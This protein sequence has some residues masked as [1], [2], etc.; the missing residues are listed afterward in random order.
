MVMH[1]G[2]LCGRLERRQRGGLLT[3]SETHDGD[4]RMAMLLERQARLG[5]ASLLINDGLE[6]D[7]VLQRVLDS[8]RSLTGAQYG[9][10]T[11]LDGSGRME[12]FL[13]SG[14]TPADAQRLWEMPGGPEIFEYVNSIPGPWRVSDFAGHARD[15]GLPEFRPPAPM[16]SFLTVPILHRGDRVGNIHMAKRQPGQEFSQEDE[17]TLVMFAAQAAMVIANARRYRDEQRARTALE[18]LVE[19]S[20]V[21][22]AV[23][24]A[25]TGAPVSFNREVAR[26]MDGL[27]EADQSPEQFLETLTVRRADGREVSLR[28]WPLA[29]ALSAGETVRAEEITLSVPDGRSVTVLLNATPIRDAGGQ[30]ESFVV[31]L[32]DLAPLEEQERLRAE[33]LGMVSHELRAPLASI[34]G[35]ATTVLDASAELDPAELRQFL[36]IIVDQADNMRDLIGDLLDVARIETGALPVDPEPA[37]PST[38]V[39]RARNTFLS[40]EGRHSIDINLPPN[41]PLVMADRRRIVQVLGNLLSNAARNSPGVPVVRVR[42]EQEGGDVAFSVVDSGRGIPSEQLPHL[43]RKFSRTEVGD[44]GLG[45]AVCKGIVEAHGGRIWAESAG[46]GLGARFTF[47]LRAVAEA[48]A[49]RPSPQ[50]EEQEETG[51]EPIL[52]VDDDPQTLR[53]VRNALSNAGY[54]PMVTADP[55]EALRLMAENRPRLVLLD[56][57]LPGFDGIELMRDMSGIADAPVVFLSAYSGDRMIAQ[58]LEAGAADYIVKPFSPTELVARVGAAL[59]RREWPHRTEPAEPYVRDGLAI[60]YARRLVSLAGQPVE[61]TAKE[62]DLLRVLSINAGRM[63]THEQ[64]LRQVWGPDKGDLRVLRSLLLRLRRKLGEDGGNPTWIHSVPRVGYR[65][66]ETETAETAEQEQP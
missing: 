44:T 56:M 47:T 3:Q 2:A 10:M 54:N 55:E 6:L 20:P 46:P 49:G 24:D 65:M 52:V 33:F 41:L 51:K 34:R 17:E 7:T 19:T 27:R 42:V 62:Y 31:T 58:A 50:A 13:A 53:Q 66:A 48:A 23:F 28:E 43:F 39:D 5:E 45:L 35:S 9:V 57:M 61:L 11:T 1:R 16:S 18:T 8:A 59:R 25:R 30:I 22:V 12:D 37:E 36:R 15:M 64:V 14:L 38:L 21:G 60:D 63:L 32:Q 29:E 40:G 4:Q 26:I